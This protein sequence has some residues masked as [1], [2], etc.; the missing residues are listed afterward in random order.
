M[1]ADRARLSQT[2]MRLMTGYQ[3]AQAIFVATKHGVPDLLR[4]G[5]KSST[6]PM[7]P[8][9]PRRLCTVCSALLRLSISHP[10]RGRRLHTV[11]RHP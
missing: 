5:A 2:L 11:A 7:P 8:A 10:A 3:A 4:N 9:R 1:E 6:S